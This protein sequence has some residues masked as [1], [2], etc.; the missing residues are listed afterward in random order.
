MKK[1]CLITAMVVMALM[2]TVSNGATPAGPLSVN[3]NRIV[4]QNDQ[5]IS[6]AG[7][8]FFWTN[9][10]WGGSK[11]YNADCLN[12]LVSDWGVEI[13]RAAMGVEDGGGYIQSPTN[14][15]DRLKTIVDASIAA[16]IYVLIDW[17]SHNAEDYESEAIDFF[18]EMATTYGSYDN[19][20]Y[21]I[22]N[23][24]L[25][26][27]SWPDDIKPYA[28]AVIAAIRA[29]DPDNLIVVGS[30]E[31]SQRVDL[32]AA[33]PITGYIN[34]A[35]TIHFYPDMG[36]TSWLRSRAT[37]ALNSGIA[38]MATE[39]GPKGYLEHEETTAWMDW[40][41]LNHV[42]HTAWAVND[43][44]EPWSFLDPWIGMETGGWTI[45]ELSIR[46]Q[47]VRDI[48]LNWDDTPTPPPDPEL[49]GH[50]K[51]DENQG[52]TV[53]DSS[54]KGN[55]G[56]LLGDPQ[57]GAGKYGSA[58]TF[59]GVGDAVD[60]GNPSV[61]D[62]STNDFTLCAW[63]KDPGGN[64]VI[65]KGGDQS[66]GKRYC[67]QV[68][69]SV[70]LLVDDNIDKH[71]VSGGSGLQDG[72]WHHVA[73][74][75]DGAVLRVYIDSGEVANGS[76]PYSPY[77]LSGT[78][79]HNAYL[80][81]VW[82]HQDNQLGDFYTGSI[83]D[84]RI[85]TWALSS[86]ELTD[87]MNDIGGPPDTTPPAAP[88]G[89]AATAGDGSVSLNWDDNGET[90]L[91]GY[92]VYRSTTSGSG[93]AQL[94]GSVLGS[95]DY[96]DNTAS[97]GTTYY[98]VVTAVDTSSN[99]SGYSNED[100]ATPDDI[101]PP[102]APTGLSATPGDGSVSLDWNDNSEPDLAGYDAYRSTDTGGP[103]DVI[104]SDL[105]SSDYTD[106]SVSN[107]TTYY[108]VVTAVDTSSNESGNSNE[109]SATPAAAGGGDGYQESG[110]VCTMEAEHAIVDQRSDNINW[111]YNSSGY[112]TT[113]DNTGMTVVWST[114]CELA[115]DV[116]ISTPGTYYMAVL[117]KAPD[118]GDDSVTA[119]INGSERDDK[120]F[121]GVAGSWEWC[122]GDDF[123][124]GS[125]SAGTHTIQLRRREDGFRIDRVMIADS[126]SKLPADGSTEFGPAESPGGPTVVFSDSFENGQWNGLWTEDSQN[127][128]DDSD[129][130]A[131]D[132]SKSAKVDGKASDATLTTGTIDLGGKTNATVTFSWYIESGLD[133][134]EYLAFD[135]STNGG[136]DWTQKEILQGNVDP[137]D[138]WHNPSV[139]VTDISGDF[140]MRFRG[141][142]SKSSEDAVVDMVR[143][144]AW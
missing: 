27:C 16:G 83:D 72:E 79:Q 98:Y 76:L 42:S 103:Y 2:S 118:N 21:E 69:S 50:W 125:L 97:N 121:T 17:H 111:H 142:M 43:K 58:L 22:Y 51:L 128:W 99:E 130:R 92:N 131:M 82:Q 1:A 11:Y 63:V 66:G 109:D 95:S 38:L 6:F 71:S 80:G 102:A 61:L 117:R 49:V 65:A 122:R 60:L 94:N 24:P 101:T 19:V 88:T 67:L 40:C 15:K 56:T 53:A 39:W 36:H 13:V 119:G 34:I 96:T 135:V 89:L 107:G 90:D 5:P 140:K 68:G 104:A 91:D 29:I 3:G 129:E 100:S 57:W 9:D 64:N 106:N 124:L 28:E 37:S 86:G 7:V 81:A 26:G 123:D 75:K 47:I 108:Y 110:G 144:L 41:D 85:Y 93:Y 143:V 18:E 8:S 116:D 73:G 136:S 120:T 112:M 87:V 62:F 137:E 115:W 45:E 33:D 114:A 70:Q 52:G 31:W 48:C 133:G 23:E 132:G 46:G 32:P 141:K 30:P 54:G 134:G 12:W 25:S 84:A 4:D 14:N 55:D 105:T 44:D 126:W 74:A 35:Y 20:I 138:T 59:D 10:G 77:D 113:I 127:D 139:T 78:S